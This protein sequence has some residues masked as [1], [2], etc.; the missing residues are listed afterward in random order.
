MMLHVKMRKWLSNSTTIKN[1]NMHSSSTMSMTNNSSTCSSLSISQTKASNSISLSKWLMISS[2]STLLSHSF[3]SIRTNYP[4]TSQCKT[5]L[6]SSSVTSLINSTNRK[7]IRFSL[8]C[9]LSYRV[10]TRVH[11]VRKMRRIKISLNHRRIMVRI[12]NSIIR[13]TYLI[14]SSLQFKMRSKMMHSSNNSYRS[15]WMKRPT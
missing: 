7:D 4:N 1:S 11:L 8:L 6:N 3:L 10:T 12:N 9:R 2:S 13:Y 5:N 15:K 14:S